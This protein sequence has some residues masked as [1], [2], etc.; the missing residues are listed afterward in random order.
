[1]TKL[2]VGDVDV[3]G[4][5]VLVRVDFNVPI[6]DGK[7]ADTTRIAAAMPTIRYIV[8]RGGRA[9]LMSHLGRPRGKID[10]KL[11]LAPVVRP[12]QEMLDRPVKFLRDCHGP[13]VEEEVRKLKDG[14]VCLLENLRFHARERQNDPGFSERLASLGDI[15]VNDAF[16]TAHRAHASTVGVTK[17]FV[18]S[19]A[20]FLIGKELEHLGRILENPKKPFFALLGGAKVSDKIQ[21]VEKLLPKLDGLLIGGA[22][23]YT[24]LKKNG[25][26]V[27]TS[28]VEEEHLDTAGSILAA[29]AKA[30]VKVVLPCDHVVAADPDDEAGAETADTIPDDRMALDI[31][32]KTIEAFTKEIGDAKT[33][34]WNGPVGMFEKKAFQAGTWALCTC[35]AESGADTIVGGGD[36][37]AAVRKFECADRMTHV[38]TG[39]GASLEFLEGRELPGIAALTEDR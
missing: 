36:T 20:G 32:P 21:V 24:F 5:R 16:G 14:D 18:Q 38:S 7:V 27:G 4:K 22:M 10:P 12:L 8:E 3:K 6:R 34:L 1:M 15:F 23:A 30:G 39:G 25:I 31:G 26:A 29:A 11:S 37:A 9:V 13:V 28:L 17:Y 33:V 35:L 19:A 2:S